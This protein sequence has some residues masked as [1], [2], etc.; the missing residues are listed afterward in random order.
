MLVTFVPS[1]PGVA[2]GADRGAHG[3]PHCGAH[4]GACCWLGCSWSFRLLP[5]G[6]RQRVVRINASVSKV[7]KKPL[8]GFA[9]TE[10]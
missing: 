8:S 7:V 10:T 3:G 1:A 6:T 2:R 9:L 4:C 5:H